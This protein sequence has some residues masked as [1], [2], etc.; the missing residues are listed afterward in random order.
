MGPFLSYTVCVPSLTISRSVA[1]SSSAFRIPNTEVKNPHCRRV[2]YKLQCGERL[3]RLSFQGQ[4]YL[5]HSSWESR[6]SPGNKRR[7]ISNEVALLCFVILYKTG[8][9]ISPVRDPHCRS[10]RYESQCGEKLPFATKCY[11][12]VGGSAILSTGDYRALRIYE[13]E[14]IG[15]QGRQYL[16][17]GSL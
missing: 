10:L 7:A 6:S 8:T 11:F 1:K 5:E 12:G 17:V 9:G 14:T 3:V 13:P 16:V 15:L 2:R 4:G